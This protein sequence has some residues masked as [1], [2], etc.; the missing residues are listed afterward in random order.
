V[1]GDTRYIEPKETGIVQGPDDVLQIHY[2]AAAGYGDPAERDPALVAEDVNEG[3]VTPEG[4]RRDYFVVVSEGE[5]GEWSVDEGG[6]KEAR[7]A[8]MERRRSAAGEPPASDGADSRSGSGAGAGSGSDAG[9]AGAHPTSGSGAVELADAVRIEIDGGAAVFSCQS[10]G[11]ELGR[12]LASYKDG[13]RSDER[14]L[15]DAVPGFVANDSEEAGELVLREHFCPG[16]YRRLDAEIVRRGD[17]SL[18]DVEIWAPPA[19]S[20]S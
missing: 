9:A 8:E 2:P 19:G 4:A 7:D 11:H 3:Y 16:C 20:G 14:A 15:A 13:A 10:C 1:H 18:V 6:T 5:E 17:H 12:D